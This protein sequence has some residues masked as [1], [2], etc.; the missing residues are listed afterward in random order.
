MLI[1]APTLAESN[2]RTS[3]VLH[4]V[5]TNFGWCKIHDPC[6]T[7]EGP[8]VRVTAGAP[9]AIYF[10]ARNYDR[11]IGM[12]FG[13]RWGQDWTYLFSLW[14][15]QHVTMLDCAQSN[16]FACSFDCV[17]GGASEVIGRA[18]LIPGSGCVEVVESIVFPGGIS[19][20]DCEF[21]VT[22]INPANLGRVCVGEG[23]ASTCES[24]VPVKDA[25]WGRIKQTYAD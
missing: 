25:T 1:S 18:H 17:T 13:V 3:I 19:T 22:P 16:F 23:G 8:T 24:V 10:I 5:E 9:H 21:N 7:A 2:A 11:M 12:Q 6:L 4:A 15:C 14:D 20:W